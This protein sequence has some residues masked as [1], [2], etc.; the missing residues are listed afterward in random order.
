[1]P[2]LHRGQLP[3]NQ[4]RISTFLRAWKR[5]D[6][7]IYTMHVVCS[8]VLDVPSGSPLLYAEISVKSLQYMEFVLLHFV[9]LGV[10]HRNTLHYC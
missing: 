6:Y 2:T 4:S 1:M 5:R 9:T 10:P 3:R 7:T 8:I